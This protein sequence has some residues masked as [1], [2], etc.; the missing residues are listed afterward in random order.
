MRQTLA[1]AH[2]PYSTFTCDG[3]LFHP[4]SEQGH[5]ISRVRHTGAERNHTATGRRSG[6]CDKGRSSPKPWCGA[7]VAHASEAMGGVESGGGGDVCS[8]STWRHFLHAGKK[9]IRLCPSHPTLYP[10]TNRPSTSL[11]PSSAS[12]TPFPRRQ[13]RC[14]SLSPPPSPASTS[15]GTGGFTRRPFHK[16]APQL[17]TSQPMD[18]VPVCPPAG[19]RRCET[20]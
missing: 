3:D 10:S 16:S 20:R 4:I 18:H 2:G 12:T 6:R 11:D 13:L 14:N 1:C 19:R 8:I 5:L 15:L 7:F 17:S 9:A